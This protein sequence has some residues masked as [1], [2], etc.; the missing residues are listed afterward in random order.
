MGNTISQL[1]ITCCQVQ[2]Q[3]MGLG[4]IHFSCC[5]KHPNK[6]PKQSIAETGLFIRCRASQQPL[7]CC[8]VWNSFMELETWMVSLTKKVCCSMPEPNNIDSLNDYV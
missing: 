1:A 5:P 2:L 3:M 7:H 8:K 6:I 4:F